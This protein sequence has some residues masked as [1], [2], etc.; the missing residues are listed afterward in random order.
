M[1]SSPRHF[2][3]LFSS[4]ASCDNTQDA[5][6]LILWVSY[7]QPAAA[8]WPQSTPQQQAATRLHSSPGA[9]LNWL[10][11][12][13]VSQSSCNQTG[14]WSRIIIVNM[15]VN[16]WGMLQMLLFFFFFFLNPCGSCGT[17][18]GH[19]SWN[20]VNPGLELHPAFHISCCFPRSPHWILAPT[21]WIIPLL[22]L[23]ALIPLW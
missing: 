4:C 23:F 20:V 14:R 3:V 13:L 9:Y 8:H 19:C 18:Q 17:G 12:Q 6:L 5:T 2:D 1:P 21:V 16:G 10:Q 11:R 22:L 7:R 15:A